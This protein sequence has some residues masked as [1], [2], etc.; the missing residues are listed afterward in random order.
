MRTQEE[1]TA[2][3]N[4]IEHLKSVSMY[5]EYLIENIEKP[6][7]GIDQIETLVRSLY[8]SLHSL[9]YIQGAISHMEGMLH[10]KEKSK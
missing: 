3:S 10:E 8:S 9:S 2:R 1:K 7:V 6:E 4:M 5:A